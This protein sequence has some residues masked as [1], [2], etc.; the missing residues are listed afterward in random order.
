[1]TFTL[2]PFIKLRIAQA[3]G[4]LAAFGASTSFGAAA[5]DEAGRTRLEA[6][7]H[8]PESVGTLVYEG[9]VFAPQGAGTRPLFTYERRVGTSPAGVASAHITFDPNGRVVIA[10]QAE[11][12]PGYALRRF[13]ATNL[14]LGYRGTAVVSDDGKRIDYRLVQDGKVTT[15]SEAVGDPV[16]AGPQLHGFILQH[17]NQLADGRKL[18]VRMIVM[19]KTQTYGFEIR[20]VEADPGQ[21]AFSITPSS[22]IVRLAIAPLKVTF[23]A[24]GG[25][26]L[27]Y[28]GRVPPMREQGGTLK[29]LDARVDYTMK[30]AAYR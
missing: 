24:A 9:A 7:R 16:V 18:P 6:L 10:E 29:N 1:M 3:V 13:E 26:V 22:F 23:D 5:L 27:R 21:A 30:V 25:H 2:G 14:Q 17:W 19:A 20:R 11:F 28:E 12:T 8:S 4:M 15:A